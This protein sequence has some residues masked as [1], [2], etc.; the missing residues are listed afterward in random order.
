MTD[1]LLENTLNEERFSW[2][3]EDLSKAGTVR[4]RYIAALQAADGH[5]LGPL[6]QF[7][8]T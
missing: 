8:R 5:D 1:L 7:V 4:Q 2:G 6:R 3:S